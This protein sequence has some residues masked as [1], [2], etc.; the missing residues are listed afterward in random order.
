MKIYY[1]AKKSAELE[2]KLVAKWGEVERYGSREYQMEEHEPVTHGHEKHAYDI[3][4]CPVKFICRNLGFEKKFT[5]E[6]I[7]MMFIGVVT[8]KLIQWLFPIDE[9]EYKSAIE[10]IINGHIDVFEEKTYPLEIKATRKRIYKKDQIPSVW[11]NQ[12]T[13]Y[14]AMESKNKGWIVIV[15]LVSCQISAYC[16]EMYRDEIMETLEEI[17]RRIGNLEFMEKEK[18]KE[19]PDYSKAEIQ[20]DE[21]EFC[22]YKF[23][24]PRRED[25]K[26]KFESLNK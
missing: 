8:Q 7:G 6:S 17:M 11:I 10:D 3:I 26:E 9:R 20:P 21:Y 4:Y 18:L 13:I 25:C 5:K 1:D 23:S 19:K 2:Q 14:M 24:C 16:V 15:N 22:D 12:I